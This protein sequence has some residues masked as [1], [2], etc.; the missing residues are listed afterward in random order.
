MDKKQR[1]KLNCA[2]AEYGADFF[3]SHEPEEEKERDEEERELLMSIRE[4]M[5]QLKKKYK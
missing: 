5:Q 4:E 2:I 1:N 3:D